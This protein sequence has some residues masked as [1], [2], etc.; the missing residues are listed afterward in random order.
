LAISSKYILS[1]KKK[2]IFNPV[3][4]AVLLTDV[5]IG[6]SASWWVGNAYLMPLVIL[7]GLLVI[8]KTQREDLLF[9]FFVAAIATISFFSLTGG[10]D[11]FTTLNNIFLHS[12]LFFFGFVMLTEPQTTPPTK[13]LHILY[14]TLVGFLF[15]PQVHISTLYS[16][17]E[18]ALIFG[19]IFSYIVSPK[20]KLL[21]HLTEKIQIA[22]DIIDFVFALDKPLAFV[23]GQYMEWTLGHPHTDSR[24]SRRYLTLASSP[25]ENTLRI[26]VKFYPN[27][28]SFKRSLATMPKESP[29][30][31]AQLSG[32]FVLPKDKTRKLV[33]VAGGIGVTPYRSIIKYLID[34][35]EKRD[36]IVLFANKTAADIVYKDLF[37]QAEHEL[38]IRTI[39]TLT[40]KNQIP[41]DWKGRVGRIDATMIENDISDW[42]ER[43]FY[44]SGPHAMVTGYEEVLKGMGLS[45]SNIKKDFFPGFV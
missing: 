37:D 42:K 17:P 5:G 40:D 18:L 13:R 41:S 36:I 43:Y 20:Q 10:S 16:T 27:G 4:I 33:L 23:P 11:F 25:T 8:R 32:E 2:H 15:A 12:S 14:G 45:E 34:M 22:P 9:S 7:G 35:K 19:N 38:G 39:Y 21:L 29:I 1:I 30:V 6:A 28:S 31:A 26:G 24:G 44:L 3:A